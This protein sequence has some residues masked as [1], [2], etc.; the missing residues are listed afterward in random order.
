MLHAVSVLC[1]NMTYIYFVGYVDRLLE[2]V[3][4]AVQNTSDVDLQD[5]GAAPSPLCSSY[6]RPDKAEAVRSHYSRFNIQYNTQ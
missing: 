2:E 5:T 3:Y 1:I 4:S 6:E